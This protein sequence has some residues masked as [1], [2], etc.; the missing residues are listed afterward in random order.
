MCNN[1]AISIIMILMSSGAVQAENTD[2]DP[3]PPRNMAEIAEHDR[4]EAMLNM[5]HPILEHISESVGKRYQLSQSDTAQLLDSLRESGRAAIPGGFGG[6]TG[7][8]ADRVLSSAATRTALLQTLT[9]Q[10]TDDYLA[11]I[12][13]RNT[14]RIQAMAN[15]IVTWLDQGLSLSAEQREQIGEALVATWDGGASEWEPRPLDLARIDGGERRWLLHRRVGRK[16]DN[17]LSPTQRRVL[18]LI[19]TDEESSS[20]E[21]EENFEAARAEIIK[22][23][24][25]GVITRQQAG[26]RLAA[27]REGPARERRNGAELEA[28]KQRLAMAEKRVRAAVEAGQVTE[29]QA[30]IRLVEMKAAMS[31]TDTTGERHGGADDRARRLVEAK[32]AAHT[33]Q[34][35]ELDARASKRLSLVTKGVVE[36]HLEAQASPGQ[37]TTRGRERADLDREVTAI[38]KAVAA[39]KVDRRQAGQRLREIRAF[40]A[41]K[42]DR[43][44][45]RSPV[46]VTNHPLYQQ[47]I[48][49]TLSETAFA[50]YQANQTAR[51]QFR[52]QSLRDLI[53]ADLDMALLLSDAQRERLVAASEILPPATDPSTRGR[54]AL[55]ASLADRIDWPD[56]GTWQQGVWDGLQEIGRLRRHADR[57]DD[58]RDRRR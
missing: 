50:S 14:R 11:H 12:D 47:T 21:D 51:V 17:L 56:L 3:A 1:I 23:E 8:H 33:E 29:Q 18:V 35:G 28:L 9:D 16:I 48:R 4:S 54:S 27:M 39:G 53:V 43:S 37:D 6:E 32:L 46:D 38:R 36:R 7:P 10:Q 31:P 52:Q 30:E 20:W 44:Q 55:I 26:R 25:A 41:E 5:L 19:P 45:D 34:L 42:D 13:A 22:M 24:R 57:N 58:Q 49:A 40:A 2:R 15:Q